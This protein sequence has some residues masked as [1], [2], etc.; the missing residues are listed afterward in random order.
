MTKNLADELQRTARQALAGLHPTTQGEE[1]GG[2]PLRRL[3]AAVFRTRYLVFGTTLFGLLVGAFL[4]TTS[5]NSYVSEG[6][7]LFTATGAEQTLVDSIRTTQTSQET[8]GSAAT[9]IL[10]TDDLM[11]RVVD[12]VTPE[13]ILAPYQPGSKDESGVKSIFFRIQR[14]WNA[15]QEDKRTPEEAL[16]LLKRTL[17]VER[18]RGTEVLI[19]RCTANNELLAQ[20]ILSAYMDEAIKWHIEKY[21]DEK[22]YEEAKKRADD[23]VVVR[24]V[25]RQALREFL[26]RKANVADFELEKKRLQTEEIEAGAQIT[27]LSDD[28]AI[29]QSLAAEAKKQIEGPAALAR[30][31]MVKKRV[32]GTTVSRELMQQDRAK[33][34]SERADL[35]AKGTKPTDPQVLEKDRAIQIITKDI[36]QLSV[37][38]ANAPETTVLEDNPDFKIAQANYSER[39]SEVATLTARLSWAKELHTNTLANLKRL[40]GLEPEYEKLSNAASIAEDNMKS[41]HITWQAAQQKHDLGLGNVSSLK[42]YQEASLPLEK[43]GPT[44]GKQLLGGLLAGLFLGLGIIVLRSLPDTVIRTRDDLERIDG[45]QVIGVMPRLDGR[46]LKRHSGLREKGW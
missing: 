6:Q 27:K 23:A 41:T 45:L 3:L 42:K 8:I 28:L 21:D 39:T 13:R 38:A 44:R 15:T 2:L 22:R 37:E 4:A 24:D 7:F 14:D 9:Y 12:R 17:T 32:D 18:P 19:A 11:K 26:D 25:A 46:N 5:A 33:R 31:T 29:A 43:E 20:E 36:E 16:K 40:M 10:S 1:P 35:L 34:A 30:Q